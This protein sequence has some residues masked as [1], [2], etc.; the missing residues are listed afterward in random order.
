ME[1]VISQ[2]RKDRKLG[3]GRLLKNIHIQQKEFIKIGL[4][5]LLTRE[6]YSMEGIQSVSLDNSN[7]KFFRISYLCKIFNLIINGKNINEHTEYWI[8]DLTL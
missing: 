3:E 8:E 1:G 4:S 5:A 7:V 6:E 2:K